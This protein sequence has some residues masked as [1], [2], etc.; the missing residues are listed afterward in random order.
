MALNKIRKG[1]LWCKTNVKKHFGSNY[2]H[3]PLRSNW[4]QMVK[5]HDE[6]L[7]VYVSR[8]N[9]LETKMFKDALTK[10]KLSN[11]G[12]SDNSKAIQMIN[13]MLNGV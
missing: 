5:D 2:S 13:D 3:K 10:G 4:I 6:P 12:H 8:K 11:V 1:K 9:E 7:E